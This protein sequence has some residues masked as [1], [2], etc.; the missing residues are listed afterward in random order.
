M[1]DRLK[2]RVAVIT[3]AG[4]G[5]GRAIALAMAGEGAKVVVNDWGGKGAAPGAPPGNADKVVAEIKDRGQVAVAQTDSVATTEGGERI[6]QTAVDNF[7]RID[8]L[9]NNAGITYDR[10]VWN[11]TEEEWDAVLD[12]N[13]KGTFNCT[14]PASIL[15]KRQRYGRIISVISGAGLVGN[16]GACNY[17]TSKA[18]MVGFMN[19]IARDLGYYGVTANMIAPVAQPDEHREAG[20]Q[21]VGMP[22]FAAAIEQRAKYGIK[23]LYAGPGTTGNEWTDH[24]APL[25]V[26][27]ASNAAAN[28]NGQLVG[29]RGETVEVWAQHSVMRTIFDR[30]GKWTVDNLCRI[31]PYIMADIFNFAP[32]QKIS[33]EKRSE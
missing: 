20:K 17:C 6:I 28:I 25:A 11:M 10:M 1:V 27:L 5:I 24:V 15:M 3:G 12:V 22:T 8:I 13:L 29:M 33:T 14:K 31:M 7:G 2:D 9:V 18:G 19:A 30:T 21:Y 16:A 26:F 4:R 23:R 32:A